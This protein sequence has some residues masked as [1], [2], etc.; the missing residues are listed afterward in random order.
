MQ[1]LK[2][3]PVTANYH[4][5]CLNITQYD[6]NKNISD[7]F[8]LVSRNI[9]VGHEFVSTIEHKKY[10]FYGSAY[11]PEKNQFE[12]VVNANKGNIS[13]D[14]N[15]IQV[16]QYFGNFLVNEARLNWN[17]FKN[18]L[19]ESNHLIY[20]F[21]GY[22]YYTGKDKNAVFEEEYRFPSDFSGKN[23]AI[24]T[25]QQTWLVSALI[26]TYFIHFFLF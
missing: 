15:A 8:W 6:E 23:S 12:F 26:V 5:W 2:D 20:N 4:K 14:W 22:R 18:K 7:N 21:N 1:I 11:H 24:A 17:H 19:E 3:N 25:H 9:Y 16:G 10:P 13:H